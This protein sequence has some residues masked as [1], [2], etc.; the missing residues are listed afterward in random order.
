MEARLTAE[1][2]EVL[3]KGRREEGPPL[4]TFAKTS[5][6]FALKTYFGDRATY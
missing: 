4:R 3:R 6:S 5:A 2:A 1:D